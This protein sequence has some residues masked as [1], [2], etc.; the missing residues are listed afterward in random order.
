KT[1]RVWDVAT[2]R[3]GCSS[4][5]LIGYSDT[6]Q[7]SADGRYVLTLGD[8][9]V[10]M[11]DLAAAISER[12]ILSHPLGVF[13]ATF[14]PDGRHIATSSL[15]GKTRLWGAETG[16]PIGVTLTHSAG[17]PKRS[18]F[19]PDGRALLTI[20]LDTGL[21]E[22]TAWIWDLATREVVVGPLRHQL[23]LPCDE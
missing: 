6:A 14:S 7:F 15:F 17:F 12:H 20:T 11:W 19:S 9:T 5:R 2:G 22:V 21:R 3:P 13:D 23:R 10:R 16:R 8:G 1:I 4:M 18:E